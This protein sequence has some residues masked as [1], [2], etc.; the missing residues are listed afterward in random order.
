MHPHIKRSD[1][2]LTVYEVSRTVSRNSFR[3]V[4]RNSFLTVSRNSFRT[5]SRNSFLTVYEVSRTYS[6]TFLPFLFPWLNQSRQPRRNCNYRSVPPP[7]TRL[8]PQGPP[9]DRACVV[10]ILGSAARAVRT[11]LSFQQTNPRPVFS[12]GWELLV[13]LKKIEI[14]KHVDLFNN[15]LFSGNVY[16][17]C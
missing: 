2:F 15:L 10:N 3:T 6:F 5:V 11:S 7:S 1:R 14:F 9:N 13:K 17:H 4:S 8:G 16:Y 12:R